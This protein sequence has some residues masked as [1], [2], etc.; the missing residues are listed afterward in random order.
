MKLQT[1]LMTK[2]LR[3]TLNRRN[4]L[5]SQG[6]LCE[7]SSSKDITGNQRMNIKDG[8]DLCK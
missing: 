7:L 6:A 2:K 3:W 4:P 8:E 1:I 5:A